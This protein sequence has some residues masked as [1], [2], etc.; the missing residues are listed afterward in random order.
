MLKRKATS[1][2]D[3]QVKCNNTSNDFVYYL[4]SRKT[5]KITKVSPTKIGKRPIYKFFV[6]YDGKYYP[7]RCILDLGSTSFVIS[8]NAAKAFKIPM[9][10]R[11]NKV[12]SNNVMGREIPTEGLHTV[13][14]GLSFRNHR[15]YDEKDHAFEVMKTSSDYDCLI[16]AWDLEKH[17][18]SG[19][20]TSHLHFPHC[21]PQ[22]FGHGKIHP[23]YS[24]TYDRRV[25]LNKDAIHICSLVQSMPSMLDRLPKQYHKFLLLFDL[26]HAEKLPDHRGCDHR[27]E[28]TTSD[29]QLR[30]AP[31]YQL[32]QEKEK[33]L[34]EYLEKM[35]REK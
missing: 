30:M 32:S 21:G 9:V 26:E 18:A 19:T 1:Q 16:P 10:K 28:L 2:L 35:I 24:V 23:E 14:L 12:R 20:T 6:N 25:A 13:P 34:V 3:H 8:P 22:C 11:T 4:P 5:Q 7:L 31:I 33:I 27:I 15:T 29:D 17:K